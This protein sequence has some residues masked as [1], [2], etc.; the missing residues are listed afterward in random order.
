MLF[1]SGKV[2]SRIRVK[3]SNRKSNQSRFF[4]AISLHWKAGEI[5][6]HHILKRIYHA[7]VHGRRDAFKF[8]NQ[9]IFPVATLRLVLMMINHN[10]Q[11]DRAAY[12][13]PKQAP[14]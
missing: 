1:A 7:R 5:K 14:P 6:H 12:L 2:I 3:K 10:H 4:P 13:P 8:K 11:K 9:D